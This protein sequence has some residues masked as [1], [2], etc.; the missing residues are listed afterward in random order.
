[1]PIKRV[2]ILMIYAHQKGNPLLLQVTPQGTH[3]EIILQNVVVIILQKDVLLL[4]QMLRVLLLI[5][6]LM[7]QLLKALLLTAHNA[8]SFTFDCPKYKWY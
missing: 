2:I 1:M 5:Q 7:P 3:F 8:K 4:P 6:M